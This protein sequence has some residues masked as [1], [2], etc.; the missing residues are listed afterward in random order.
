MFGREFGLYLGTKHSYKDLG[1]ILSERDLGKPEPQTKRVEVPTKDGSID[2]TE[3]V[4]NDVRY[5]D[6]TVKLTFYYPEFRSKWSAKFSELQNML[7]GQKLKLIFD[8]DI[9]FYYEG[10]L[11]VNEWDSE[12]SVGKIVITAICDPYKYDVQSS[13]AEWVW[14]TFDFETGVINEGGNIVVDGTAT[15]DII[16]RRKKSYPIITASTAM[17]VS[18]DGETFDLAKGENKIYDILFSEGIN[19]LTFTGTGT[20]TIDYVG[21]SL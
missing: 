1:L 18:Y 20:V 11:S 14:D 4:S 3:S 7:N 16:A 13:A 17:T 9:A 19:E 15:I 8:D 21:G 12:G 10:R 2:M 5:K 6:R